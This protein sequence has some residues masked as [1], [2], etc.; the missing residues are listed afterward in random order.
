MGF[1]QKG[2][3]GESGSVFIWLTGAALAASVV[4]IVGIVVLVASRGL[5]VFWPREL[6]EFALRDGKKYVVEELARERMP[7]TGE[8]PEPGERIQVR[9]ANRDLYGLDFRW[10]PQADIVSRALPSD[11]VLVER[12]EYGP[13]QGFLA[14][15][16]QSSGA[17]IEATNPERF[18]IL[19]G[20]SSRR[21]SGA[22]TTRS[23][24]RGSPSGRSNATIRRRARRRRRSS[25]SSRPRSR[26][27]S[28][29]TRS[30]AGRPT[31]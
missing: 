8:D 26:R 15:I 22:S 30:C 31:R 1:R 10:I 23:N 20:P 2:G 5:G 3:Q 6:V 27:S 17:A 28:A 14:R 11:A 4:M 18:A 24:A 19:E 9:L 16:E 29:S 12:Q 25:R 7:A 13:F 21:R